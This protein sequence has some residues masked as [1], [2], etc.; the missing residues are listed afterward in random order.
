MKKSKVS[1]FAN[2]YG[3]LVIISLTLLISLT[4]MSQ[5][6]QSANQFAQ[7][8]TSVLLISLVGI[9]ILLM[10]LFRALK[11]LR[12]DYKSKQPGSRITTRLTSFLS[13]VLGV[14]FINNLSIF[15]IIH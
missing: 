4:I 10:M 1:S 6:L 12:S 14:P 9:F 8:Y 11:K 7:L 15:S 3:W 5:V 2:Q 13:L